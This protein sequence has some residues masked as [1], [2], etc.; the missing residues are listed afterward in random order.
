MT[1]RGDQSAAAIL[2]RIAELE[3][4]LAPVDIEHWG[5]PC[6]SEG[7]PL[8]LVASHIGLG[9][10]RQAGWIEE[11]ARSG[12]PF[13]FT[14]EETND[15]NAEA[16]RRRGLLSKMSALRFVRDRA[17]RLA[18]LARSLTEAQLDAIVYSYEGK[19]RSAEWVINVLAC[20]HIDEHT[21]SIRDTLAAG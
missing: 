5:R 21:R 16:A 1:Q 11:H 9:L 19:S 14:W 10:D 18:S 2:T 6:P 13:A 20:R 8:G 15:L 17:E 3:R 4:T 12:E 7:W